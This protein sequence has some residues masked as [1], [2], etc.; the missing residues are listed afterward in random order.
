MAVLSRIKARVRRVFFPEDHQ[1]AIRLLR[2]WSSR[3]L[4][5][6]GVA[7]TLA[8]GNLRHL[9]WAIRMAEGDPRDLL[10][11]FAEER[12]ARRREGDPP[13]P[14]DEESAFLQAIRKK[15]TDN[16]QR[17]VYADWLEERGDRRS[18]YLRVLCDWM[19]SEEDAALIARERELRVGLDRDWLAAI[20]GMNPPRKR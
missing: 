20:R 12:A 10:L 11:T 7:L 1:E 13:P 16:A 6:H 19:R 15:P 3:D 18:D 14:A 17:L 4:H 5:L 9:R 8:R 2:R